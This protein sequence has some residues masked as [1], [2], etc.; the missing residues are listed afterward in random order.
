MFSGLIF[1]FSNVV[2]FECFYFQ[3]LS[4]LNVFVYK[5]FQVSFFSKMNNIKYPE[6]CANSGDSQ[7]NPENVGN[8]RKQNSYP[9]EKEKITKVT[10]FF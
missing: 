1:L 9:E 2:R 7:S 5:C 10:C 4:G 8:R 6:L 3:M